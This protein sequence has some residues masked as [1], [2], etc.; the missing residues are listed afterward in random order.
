VAKILATGRLDFEPIA[1][2]AKRLADR[3]H[4]RDAALPPGRISGP[5]GVGRCRLDAHMHGARQVPA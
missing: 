1:F 5:P 2:A 4:R 3:Q